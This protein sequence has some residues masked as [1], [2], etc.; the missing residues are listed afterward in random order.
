MKWLALSLVFLTGPA[1]AQSQSGGGGGPA[2]AIPAGSAIIGK[3]GIDQTT[4]GTTNAVAITAGTALIGK[5]GLDQTTPGTT[6]AVAL[7][8]IG[9]TTTASGNGTSGAGNQ[10]V[11]IAS[12]NTAFSVNTVSTNNAAAQPHI[13]G[14]HV[15]KHITT[16]TDTQ[17]VAASGSTTIYVCD[18]SISFNGT[19]NVY[20]EKATSGTCATLTQIDQAWYGVANSGKIAANPYYQGLNTGASAQLCANTSQAVT[21]DIAVNYDQ[22]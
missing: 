9:S 5:A 13:C 20:L 16:A 3:V 4:P 14:S 12:D 19:G 18:Y 2:T 7:A 21:I 8:Q 6:N 15:F 1:L 22:Y 10:R 11:N 17:V